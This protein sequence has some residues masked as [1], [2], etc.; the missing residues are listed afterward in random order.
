MK[1]W[2]M[3]ELAVASVFLLEGCAMTPSGPSVQVLP[4][5]NKP[6]DQFAQDQ[7]FC[8]QYATDQ[9]AGQAEHA[10]TVA[11]G[12][13]VL[14]TV[15]GAGLGAAIGGGRGAGIGAAGGALLGT[16][17]GASGSAD[18]AGGIQVQYD[19]AYVACMLSHGNRLPAPRPV[20]VQP[21]PVYVQPAPYLV[22]PAP[23]V[24]EP[25]YAPGYAPGYGPRY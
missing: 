17:V 19:N 1:L 8:R 10:N 24:V 6:F 12:G 13:A 9:T 25:G 3:T 14:G 22:Q 11:V 4:G 21:A 20:Y 7:G 2:T 15:L 18:V 16:G 5:P 23:Y